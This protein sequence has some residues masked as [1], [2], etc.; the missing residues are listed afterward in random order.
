MMFGAS[1]E[2]DDEFDE[3]YGDYYDSQEEDVSDESGIA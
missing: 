3:D 1:Q 2:D